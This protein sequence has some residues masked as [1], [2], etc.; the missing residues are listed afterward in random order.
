MCAMKKVA[1]L[2]GAVALSAVAPAALQRNTPSS[3]KPTLGAWGVD[4]TGMDKSVKPGDDFFDYANGAWYKNAVIPADRTATGSFPNLTILSEQRMTE[5]VKGLEAKPIGQLTAEEKKIRD[6]YDAY[7][8]TAAIEKNGLAPARKDLDA[9]AAI[10]T[11][12]DVAREMASPAVPDAGPFALTISADQKQPTRYI[13]QLAQS[14]LAMPNRDYYLKDDPALAATRDA[15]R[16]YLATMLTLAGA[17]DAAGRA[18]AVFTLETN[19]AKAHWTAVESRDADKTYNPM[20][21]A[22]LAAYA[23]GFPWAAFFAAKGI[24]ETASAGRTVILR[25]NTAFPELAKVFAATPVQVWRD[26][27]T[28]HYLHTM[29]PYLPK[30]FDTADFDFFEKTLAG[31]KERSE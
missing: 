15:Y 28:V 8:D 10:K 16:K 17:Q 24:A 27:L 6:L 4:L 22:Q 20:T 23:P 30:A 12:E 14:G 18:D 1:L 26:Y 31:Q 11:L 9:I 29:A 21:G 19:I 13:E 7:T 5:I 3:Q 2:I 25:Q